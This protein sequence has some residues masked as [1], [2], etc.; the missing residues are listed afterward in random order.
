M[1]FNKK[2]LFETIREDGAEDW[3]AVALALED[4]AYLKSIGVEDAQTPVVEDAHDHAT[5]MAVSRCD[6]A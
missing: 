6:P 4:G 2:T 3:Q 1:I 5:L